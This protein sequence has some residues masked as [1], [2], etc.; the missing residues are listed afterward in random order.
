MSARCMKPRRV[1][2]IIKNA[3]LKPSAYSGLKTQIIL[4]K[5]RDTEDQWKLLKNFFPDFN[6]KSN[7]GSFE[8]GIQPGRKSPTQLEYNE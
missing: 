5:T 6:L 1:K 2:L 3:N 4:T 8:T 7:F